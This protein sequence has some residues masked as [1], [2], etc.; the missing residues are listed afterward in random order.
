MD[1][2][3]VFIPYLPIKTTPRYMKRAFAKLGV[4]SFQS[5]SFRQYGTGSTCPY[6]TAWVEFKGITRAEWETFFIHLDWEYKVYIQH[7]SGKFRLF[8][9]KEKT[10]RDTIWGPM[11]FEKP[12]LNLH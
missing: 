6:Y 5:I 8:K 10:K 3:Q 12:M 9:V 2:Y 11:N 1:S 4:K 7:K